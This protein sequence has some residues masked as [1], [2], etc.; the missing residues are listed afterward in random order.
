M[1]SASVKLEIFVSEPDALITQPIPCG[2][3]SKLVNNISANT[4]VGNMLL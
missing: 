2:T 3:R 1:V 4:H